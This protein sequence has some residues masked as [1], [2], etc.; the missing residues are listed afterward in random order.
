VEHEKHPVFNL[1]IPKSCPGVPAEILNPRKTW[2]DPA[3]YDQAAEKLRGM[4]RE[5]FQKKGF[6]ALGIE[7][8]M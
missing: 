4:F 5:N 7:A 8:V 6:G 2:K 1:A 3:A